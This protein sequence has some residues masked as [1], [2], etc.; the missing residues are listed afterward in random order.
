M[1]SLPVERTLG[2]TYPTRPLWRLLQ[3]RT[4]LARDIIT[5]IRTEV[6]GL[7]IASRLNAFDGVPYQKSATSPRG[8]PAL[9]QT[10]VTGVWGTNVDNPLEPD[11]SEPR[12]WIAEM[13][14]WESFAST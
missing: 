1:P 13:R 12:A 7:L 8:E 3:N 4:R 9:W 2:G 14:A 10:P 11:L 6:P 5:A